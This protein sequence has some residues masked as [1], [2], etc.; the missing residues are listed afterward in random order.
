MQ[1]LKYG[2]L[3]TNSYLSVVQTL[4]LYD[5]LSDSGSIDF[6]VV[7]NKIKLATANMDAATWAQLNT[8]L[9]LLADDGA[10]TSEVRAI[11]G[12]ETYNDG[13]NDIYF[14]I[15][16]EPFTVAAASYDLKVV[17]PQNW[18]PSFSIGA[19]SAVSVNGAADF[20]AANQSLTVYAT[21]PQKPVVVFGGDYKLTNGIPANF[22]F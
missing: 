22:T 20:I 19:R 16:D 13:V 7:A 5:N 8:S 17:D 3:F 18:Q 12:L 9:Y 15:V 1:T 10:N 14:I 21:G 6:V 11:T 2:K 4:P